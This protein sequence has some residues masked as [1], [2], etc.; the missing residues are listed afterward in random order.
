MAHVGQEFA[1][2]TAGCFCRFLRITHGFL[3][4]FALGYVLIEQQTARAFSF[5][6]ERDGVGFHVHE[7]SVAAAPLSYHV[8]AVPSHEAISV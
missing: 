1:F 4:Q 5:A 8:H 6:P 2:R 3:C 7:A